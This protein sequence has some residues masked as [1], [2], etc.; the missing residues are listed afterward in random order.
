M[1]F[2]QNTKS[3]KSSEEFKLEVVRQILSAIKTPRATA[4]LKRK[5]DHIPLFT[6]PHYMAEFPPLPEKMKK[7]DV[8]YVQIP[9]RKETKYFCKQCN[10]PFCAVPC[11]E[12]YHTK[13]VF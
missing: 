3:K 1:L 10:I 2:V 12:I 11:F 7:K 5:S 9:K 6:E 4:S 13:R 8:M